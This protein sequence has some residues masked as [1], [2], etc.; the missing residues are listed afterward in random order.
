MELTHIQIVAP[1][2][3]GWVRVSHG[4]GFAKPPRH[5][6]TRGAPRTLA[7]AAVPPMFSARQPA[8]PLPNTCRRPSCLPPHFHGLRFISDPK[9]P[10]TPKNPCVQAPILFFLRTP[11]GDVL[12]SFAKDQDTLDETLPDTIHVRAGACIGRHCPVL[13]LSMA[14]NGHERGDGTFA[15][16][17]PTSFVCQ[18]WPGSQQ[19]RARGDAFQIP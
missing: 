1:P 16:G 15:A 10:K 2:A 13:H 17:H 11:V 7:L 18:R 9:T 6:L 19:E 12:N 8:T 3:T 5:P 4:S 14:P